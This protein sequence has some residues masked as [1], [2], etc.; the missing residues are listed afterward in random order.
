MQTFILNHYPAYMDDRTS[1]TV[2]L[3]DDLKYRFY[4]SISGRTVS[5]WYDPAQDR[6]FTATAL[7]D[8]PAEFWSKLVQHTTSDTGAS[9]MYPDT[10]FEMRSAPV[11]KK[12]GFRSM[13]NYDGERFQIF[14][15]VGRDDSAISVYDAYS[16][17]SSLCHIYEDYGE[18]VIKFSSNVKS[19]DICQYKKG[20]FPDDPILSDEYS[21]DRIKNIES[22]SPSFKSLI[23]VSFSGNL[24][25]I[26]LGEI[27]CIDTAWYDCY[28]LTSLRLPALKDIAKTYS[29]NCMRNLKHF[30]APQL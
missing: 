15:D 3:S 22:R 10:N 4:K 5:S 6:A 30:Y 7:S 17:I 18:H 12:I 14:W 28:E 16:P 21:G 27:S 25:S 23:N 13:P 29:V 2:V 20:E 8:V 9:L 11:S 19:V 26:T 1:L 24:E